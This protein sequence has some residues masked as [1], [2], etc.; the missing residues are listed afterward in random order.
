MKSNDFCIDSLVKTINFLIGINC[1]CI[2]ANMS[3]I[4]YTYFKLPHTISVYVQAASQ[5]ERLCFM[6][7]N[8][9]WS[10]DS[11]VYP[12]LHINRYRVW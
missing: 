10:I 11:A 12:G 1:V 4:V 6:K 9:S 5:Y 2:L 3:N 7:A 8:Q